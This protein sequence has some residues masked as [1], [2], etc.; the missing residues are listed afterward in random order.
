MQS[1]QAGVDQYRCCPHNYGMGWPYFTEELWLATRGRRPRRRVVRAEHGHRDGRRRHEGDRRPRTPTTP[2]TR[3]SRSPSST[4]QSVAFPLH[5]RVPGWCHGPEITVNGQSVAAS[6]GPAFAE[7]SRTWDERR[8]GAAAPAAAHDHADLDRQPRRGQRRPRSA[9]LLAAHRR[10]VRASTRATTPSPRTRCTPPL[11]GTTA[12]LSASG[13]TFSRAGGSLADN[14][15]T[16]DGTP[17]HIT[18]AGPA[19]SA[20]W[21]ADDEQVVAPLQPSPARSTAAVETRHADPDGRR[22]AAHHVV[23]R[24]WRRTAPPGRRSPPFRRIVNKNSGKVLAVDGMSTANSA[25]VVQFDNTRHRRPRLAAHR[26]GR[27][28]GT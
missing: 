24:P 3:P 28:A 23:S 21:V 5:L 7:V 2:S 1:Y 9:H 4:R 16:H 25:R 18:A 22:P 8:R 11:P 6:D 19:A 13:L 12:W 17:V 26:Q 27:R 10:A 14:P 20:E 15:F